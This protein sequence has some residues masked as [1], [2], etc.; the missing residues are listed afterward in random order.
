M[1][2]ELNRHN[3]C[4]FPNFNSTFFSCPVINKPFKTHFSMI[5]KSSRNTNIV[6]SSILSI[7][8]NSLLYIDTNQLK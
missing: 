4:K 6:E 2:K 5:T 8:A 3:F 1:F 7:Y